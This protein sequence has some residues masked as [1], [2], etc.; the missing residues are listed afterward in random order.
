[1]NFIRTSE[2]IK[3][4][5]WHYLVMTK[6]MVLYPR[7]AYTCITEEAMYDKQKRRQTMAALFVITN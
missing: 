7:K 1:M 6:G 2:L 3:T 5:I 4:I